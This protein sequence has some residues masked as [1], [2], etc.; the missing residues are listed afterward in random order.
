M[1]EEEISK[2]SSLNVLHVPSIEIS[3]STVAKLSMELTK[4][5]AGHCCYPHQNS[6]CSNMV[7]PC[8]PLVLALVIVNAVGAKCKYRVT[9]WNRYPPLTTS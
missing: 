3:D 8:G 2:L 9:W 1:K 4:G 6:L 7:A 5:K